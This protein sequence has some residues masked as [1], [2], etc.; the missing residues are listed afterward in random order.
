[1]AVGLLLVAA[2]IWGSLAIFFSGPNSEAVRYAL[3]GLFAALSFMAFVALFSN[4]WR[5]RFLLAH[6]GVFIGLLFWFFNIQPSND[7][8]WQPDV[9]VLPY[10]TVEGEQVTV[11]NIRNFSYR[12]ETDYTPAYYD[13]RFNLSELI[14]VDVVAVYWMGPAIAHVFLSFEFEGGEHLAVSIETRKE[15][16]ESYSTLKGFFRQYELYYVVADERDVIGLRSNYRN[17]PPEDVYV[18][19]VAGDI[20]KGRTLFMEYI[21]R[22]NSLKSKPE[23]Y[24]TLTTNCTTDIWTNTHVNQSQLALNWKILASGY[25][26]EYLYEQQ[27]LVMDGLTFSDLQK[28]AHINSRA[29]ASGI[30][31]DFSVAIRQKK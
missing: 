25:V 28:R 15:K 13:K 12:S 6:L 5:W 2:G 11:H 3:T 16:G 26:P 10:A 27:R 24:N 30:N 7:R 4:G 8:D 31:E 19:R 20:E 23:F 1:M 14:G 17:A 21:R 18:Y 29:I 22:I 9:A